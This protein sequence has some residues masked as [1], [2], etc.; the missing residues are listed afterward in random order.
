MK[1]ARGRPRI[2]GISLAPST[3]HVYDNLEARK[4]ISPRI[5]HALR[6]YASGAVPTKKAAAEAMGLS[7]Q[8]L[9][10]ASTKSPAAQGIHS[11]TMSAIEEKTVS[12]SALLATLSRKAVEQIGFMM[13]N[14]DS[15]AIRL[16]AAIDLADRGPES[17]KIQKHQVES[18]TLTGKDVESLAAAMMES[19]RIESLRS[20]VEANFEQV[21]TQIIAPEDESKIPSIL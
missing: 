11:K 18:F 21:S 14:S 17:S 8:T 15:E 16:K 20:K 9:Y 12:M 6:L 5:T 1:R 19:G 3:Q 7:P 2:D 10:I 13:E 4:V